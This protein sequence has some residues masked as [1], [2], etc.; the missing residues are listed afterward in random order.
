MGNQMTQF[1]QTEI[2]CL[3]F[4]GNGDIIICANNNKIDI[5]ISTDDQPYVKMASITGDDFI[6]GMPWYI[7]DLYFFD[8]YSAYNQYVYLISN[9][10]ILHLFNLYGIIQ[11]SPPYSY[12]PE[13]IIAQDLCK[14]VCSYDQVYVAY[15]DG[16]FDIYEHPLKF[17]RS[18]KSPIN[19]QMVDMTLVE[20]MIYVQYASTLYIYNGKQPVHNAEYGIINFS[21][22]CQIST[23]SVYNSGSFICAFCSGSPNNFYETYQFECPKDGQCILSTDVLV[24]INRPD[25]ITKPVYEGSYEIKAYNSESTLQVSIPII[26]IVDG[27]II[28]YMPQYFVLEKSVKFDEEYKLDLSKV[29]YGQ[30]VRNSLYINGVYIDQS[31]VENLPAYVPSRVVEVG[32]YNMTDD[33]FVA[34]LVIPNSEKVMMMTSN[35][36]IY[37][38]NGTA[39]QEAILSI[40][41]AEYMNQD[42]LRCQ[43]LE[44]VASLSK[45]SLLIANFCSYMITESINTTQTI[46][47]YHSSIPFIG[48]WDINHISGSVNNFSILTISSGSINYLRAIQTDETTFEVYG[49]HDNDGLYNLFNPNNDIYKFRIYYNKQVISIE[50][51]EIINYISLDLP[52]FFST[53]FDVKLER[54]DSIYLYTTDQWYGIRIIHSPKN[55]VSTCIDGIYQDQKYPVNAIGLCDDHLYA[56]DFDMEMKKYSIKNYLLE[57]K[58]TFYPYVSIYNDPI[59][60]STRIVCSDDNKYVATTYWSSFNVFNIRLWDLKSYNSSSIVSDIYVS[61]MSDP[62]IVTS[63]KFINSYTISVLGSQDSIYSSFQINDKQLILPSMNRSQY[64]LMVDK[65]GTD[66]FFITI[67]AENDNNQINSTVMLVKRSDNDKNDDKNNEIYWWVWMFA[68]IGIVTTLAVIWYG[69]R[70]MLKRKKP[71]YSAEQPLTMG[72][73]DSMDSFDL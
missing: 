60:S 1:W 62:F 72:E 61:Q 55:G 19:E 38:V 69:I 45:S 3:Y 44:S 26:L 63:L 35:G 58:E 10:N 23:S 14:V 48:V 52:K 22:K 25:L 64:N 16:S 4:L 47:E 67:L 37:V 24:T 71:Q 34:H 31:E 5:Y 8:Q 53:I 39:F 20:N 43:A 68:A 36:M 73:M 54:S 21:S 15:N 59:A 56:V 32:Y 50:L 66:K 33:R 40:N 51:I 18:I 6:D 27:E 2:E 41:L 28:T 70:H 29:F 11:V 17:V 7:T 13:N 42:G 49:T 9:G 46:V 12:L 57:Y 30:S 65:W